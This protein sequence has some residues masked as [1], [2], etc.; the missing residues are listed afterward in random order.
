MMSGG[1][2]MMSIPQIPSGRLSTEVEFKARPSS[3]LMPSPSA[4]GT[5]G[6]A[7][8]PPVYAQE[9]HT[10]WAELFKRQS[11]LLKGRVCNEYLAGRSL[12]NYPSD[13]VPTLAELSAG[14][15]S[16]TGWQI[17]RVEGY[18]PE[19]IFFKL[20]ANKCFPCTDFIR[21]PT[22]LEYT[23]APDMFH[24]LMGHLPLIA[25]TRFASFFHAYGLAGSAAKTE[26]EVAWLGRI[27]WFTV[28]FGLMNPNA[29]NPALRRTQDTTIYGAGIVSS[30]GEIAHSLSEIVKKEPFNPELLANR[31]FDIHHMQDT[32]FEIASFDEL[33][34]EFRRWASDKGLLV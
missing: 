25:N 23:P 4:E 18:V 34:S 30:V 20:L 32:L 22:E 16:A 2:G 24:D 28:E 1:F 14:L 3:P 5:I 6:V 31:V 13:R 11:A 7:I 12:L 26:E 9:Q 19:N 29:H 17:I 8:R 15:Q 10:T 33:E 21:H 27:Y